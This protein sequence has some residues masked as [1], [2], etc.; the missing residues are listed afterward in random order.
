MT[1]TADIMVAETTEAADVSSTDDFLAGLGEDIEAEETAEASAAVAET[2]ETG[3]ETAPAAEAVDAPQTIAYNYNRQ[4]TELPLAAV[5][6]IAAALGMEPNALVAQLQKGGNY[7]A[8]Y[9]VMERQKPFS[10]ILDRFARYAQSNG[11][12]NEDAA[13]RLLQALDLA[14]AAQYAKQLRSEYP[15]APQQLIHDLALRRAKEEREAG[16]AQKTAQQLQQQERAR[17][18]QWV[19][20]FSRHAEIKSADD[21]S[22]RMLQAL[23]N[24]EDPEAVFMAEKN[25][26]LEKQLKEL[27]QKQLN[28]SRSS[29]SAKTTAS[30][31]AM[32]NFLQGFLS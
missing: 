4:T 17:E 14:E 26:D 2:E 10:S 32:D 12:S 30:A 29:G 6:D 15:D 31:A 9:S 8:M 28:A 27:R 5:S 19:S 16:A 20:F 24:G 21:L 13:T 25:A 1:D 23:E 11:F 7:D 22:A 18:A 3:G